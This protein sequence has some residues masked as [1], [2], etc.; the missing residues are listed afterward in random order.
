MSLLF[1]PSLPFELYKYEMA[2][3][4]AICCI[5]LSTKMSLSTQSISFL[6]HSRQPSLFVFYPIFSISLSLLPH[7]QP[8]CLPLLRYFH[9]SHNSIL[10]LKRSKIPLK[11]WFRIKKRLKMYKINLKWTCYQNGETRREVEILYKIYAVKSCILSRDELSIDY[12]N[13]YPTFKCDMFVK[14][15]DLDIFIS[16]AVTVLFNLHFPDERG[17]VNFEMFKRC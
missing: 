11:R 16:L 14:L 9:P 13:L 7:I 17:W 6:P 12:T 4:F 1:L 5:S 8:V 3:L 10:F 2:F 15:F